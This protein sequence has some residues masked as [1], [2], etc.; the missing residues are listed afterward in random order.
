MTPALRWE[1]FTRRL[2]TAAHEGRT[3]DQGMPERQ[4]LAEL[5]REFHRELA[6]PG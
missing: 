4:L 5:L 6:P 2:F 3:D 1:K